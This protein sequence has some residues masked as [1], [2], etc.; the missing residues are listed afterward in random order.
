M[1]VLYSGLDKRCHRLVNLLKQRLAM[2]RKFEE[3]LERVQQNVQET[4][5]MVELL[6]LQGSVDLERLQTAADRLK[7]N[8]SVF[9][10]A[11]YCSFNEVKQIYVGILFPRLFEF[12]EKTFT[13]YVLD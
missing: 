1:N 4:D 3:Q 12:T 5:Y 8:S 13:D 6:T 11:E 10:L 9:F 7:V 2:W